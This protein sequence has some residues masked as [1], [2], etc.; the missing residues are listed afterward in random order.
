MTPYL[1]EALKLVLAVFAVSQILVLVAVVFVFDWGNKHEIVLRILAAVSGVLIYII[2]VSVGIKFPE[3]ILNAM[4][5]PPISRLPAEA[6]IYLVGFILPATVGILISSS[7]TSYIKNHVEIEQNA[8]KST[9][10]RWMCLIFTIILLLY[11]DLYIHCY[12]DTGE[13]TD[14][15]KSLLPN[16]TFM[17]SV[18]LFS[19]FS[20]RP[21]TSATTTRVGPTDERSGRSY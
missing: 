12:K 18:L 1:P 11:C 19:I 4:Y 14:I 15:L 7:M 13:N 5:N 10:I 21:S 20:F 17:L 3:L 6:G 2:A 8:N 9:R 16:S